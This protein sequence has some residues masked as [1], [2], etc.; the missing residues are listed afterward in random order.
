L[1]KK[2]P[3]WQLHSLVFLFCH[4]HWLFGPLFFLCRLV[5]FLLFNLHNFHYLL[6]KIWMLWKHNRNL[7]SKKFVHPLHYK[8][9]SCATLGMPFLPARMH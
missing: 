2:I 4:S 3:F 9:S 7:L 1:K 8:G 5:E 6:H